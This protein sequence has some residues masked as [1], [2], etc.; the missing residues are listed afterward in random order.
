MERLVQTPAGRAEHGLRRD[1]LLAVVLVQIQ[2]QPALIAI[3]QPEPV[4]A[5]R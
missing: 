3:Q 1:A 2:I 4:F 5:S